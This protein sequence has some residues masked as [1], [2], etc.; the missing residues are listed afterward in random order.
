MPCT[1]TR[2]LFLKMYT[3]LSSRRVFFVV[4]DGGS[5]LDVYQVC[6][7][8]VNCCNAVRREDCSRGVYLRKEISCCKEK[9]F[10]KHWKA[11]HSL[12]SIQERDATPPTSTTHT[13]PIEIQPKILSHLSSFPI[14][15]LH[16]FK[17]SHKSLQI[18]PLNI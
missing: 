18:L 13:N 3:F 12:H 7:Y 14:P 6:F 16:S 8:F 10:W 2:L 5:F 17:L 9:R 15:M 1:P 4:D 11:N